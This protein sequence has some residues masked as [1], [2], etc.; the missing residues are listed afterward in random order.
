MSDTVDADME[1]NGD[2]LAIDEKLDEAANWTDTVQV[3]MGDSTITL[4]HRLLTERER[5]KLRVRLPMDELQAY[6][7]DEMDADRERLLA[8]QKKDSLTDAEEAEL[9]DLHET[10]GQQ[11]AGLLSA[12][13]EDGVNALMDAGKWTVQPTAADVRDL[14]DA[15]PDRQQAVFNG[16]VPNPLTPEKARD[17]LADAIRKKIEAQPYLIK[18]HLGMAAL[19]ETNGVTQGN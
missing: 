3:P 17:P 7:N 2:F 5:L 4:A 18:L 13:G 15:P 8:L 10:A 16:N 12:L 14:I 9:R 6:Q 19:N 11:T 1:Y